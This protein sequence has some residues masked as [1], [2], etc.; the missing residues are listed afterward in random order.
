MKK[1][2]SNHTFLLASLTA[3]VL[4]AS[5][6]VKAGDNQFSIGGVQLCSN[7]ADAIK[8]LRSKGIQGPKN[9]DQA[10]KSNM[11]LGVVLKNQNNIVTFTLQQHNGKVTSVVYDTRDP[12]N[13]AAEAAQTK[14]M[15]EKVA[16]VRKRC[17][18]QNGMEA[19]IYRKNPTNITLRFYQSPARL[20]LEANSICK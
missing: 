10:V 13:A 9:I 4:T 5:L 17:R 12:A 11:N 20:Y 19:C 6:T 18:N 7:T 3:L 1:N 16:G 8:M 14:A 2:K 15:I